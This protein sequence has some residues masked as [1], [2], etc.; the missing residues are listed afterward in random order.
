MIKNVKNLNTYKT[1]IFKIMLV[2]VLVSGVLVFL[3]TNSFFAASSDDK[4]TEIYQTNSDNTALKVSDSNFRL[5]QRLN[6]NLKQQ[7]SII[8]TKIDNLRKT[9]AYSNFPA[10]RLNVDTPMFGISDIVNSEL[11]ITYEVSNS[12]ISSHYSINDIIN[13]NKIKVPSYTVA[14]LV[15]KTRDIEINKNMTQSDANIVIFKLLEYLDQ[16]KSVSTRLDD[17]INDILK[18][19]IN[20]DKKNTIDSI[21]NDIL[22]ISNKN[23]NVYN[24]LDQLYLLKSDNIVEY[25]NQFNDMYIV[26]MNYK[27]LADNNLT[28]LEVLTNINKD[29]ENKQLTVINTSNDIQKLYNSKTLDINKSDL[30]SNVYDK[31]KYQNDYI[32]KYISSSDGTFQG[33]RNFCYDNEINNLNALV[34]KTYSITSKNIS[35]EMQ[36]IKDDIEKQNSDYQKSIAQQNQSQNSN[37]ANDKNAV[38]DENIKLLKSLATTY[39]DYLNKQAQF[40]QDNIDML[41]KDSS[42]KLTNIGKNTNYDISNYIEYVN[43]D[44]YNDINKIKQ[45]VNNSSMASMEDYIEKLKNELQTVLDNNL[46]I[47]KLYRSQ[48]VKSSDMNR[49]N[50][51]TT[52]NQNNVNNIK[53]GN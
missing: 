23:T 27:K 45:N 3:S 52:N 38:N 30:L 44:Y 37:N 39:L 50:S 21:N 2:V 8:N 35:D 29:L 18:G 10:V 15:V 51:I 7:I 36:K 41:I 12:D 28:K 53:S 1:K 22:D 33:N 6:D 24:N 11:K 4:A 19:Y 40:M 5:I 32:V 49:D 16:A 14:S 20:K 43:I 42:T 47:N 48:Q 34:E 26:L 25:T 13:Q 9:D 17:Q 31:I 46:K